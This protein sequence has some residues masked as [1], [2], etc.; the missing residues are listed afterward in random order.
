MG[1]QVRLIDEARDRLR[2]RER[3]AA[4]TKPSRNPSNEATAQIR[5]QVVVF[6]LLPNKIM[7]MLRP[8]YLHVSN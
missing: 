6:T 3:D 4:R 2:K 1:V 8:G 5:A 7:M